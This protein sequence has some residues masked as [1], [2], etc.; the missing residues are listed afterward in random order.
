MRRLTVPGKGRLFCGQLHLDVSVCSLDQHLQIRA[1]GPLRWHR[2]D[3]AHEFAGSFQQCSGISKRRAVEEANVDVCG[4][5]IDVAEG[6]IGDADRGVTVVQELGDIVAAVAE[7]GKPLPRDAGELGS[8]TF[9]PAVNPRLVLGR[10]VKPQKAGCGRALQA[11]SSI[12]PDGRGQRRARCRS[13][14]ACHSPR[15]F[16]GDLF[17]SITPMTLPSGS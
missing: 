6:G 14:S 1:V 13:G 8:A 7:L 16:S 2:L 12:C 9:E 11:V 17:A 3:V 15:V 5:Y 10:A 4:E